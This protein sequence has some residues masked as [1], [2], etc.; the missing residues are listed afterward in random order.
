[1]LTAPV[2]VSVYG[3]MGEVDH[4]QDLRGHRHGRHRQRARHA[5]RRLILGIAESLVAG[6]V[7][8]QYR[9][10]V[11]FVTLIWMLMLRPHGLFSAQARF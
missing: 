6:Y 3:G 1:M 4:L 7:G 8:L 10:T 5:L 9:D 11:G 2:N